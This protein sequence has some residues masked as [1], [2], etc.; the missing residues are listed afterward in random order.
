MKN[1]ILIVDDEKNIRTTL[2]Y[3]LSEEEYEIDTADDGEQAISILIG[4]EKRYDLVLLDIKMPYISGMDVLRRLRASK[5][6]TNIIMMTAYGTVKEA[7]EAMK[8]NVID[9]ISKPFSLE[10]I[11]KIIIAVLSREN[12]TENTLYT[13]EQYI[14]FAKL[15]ITNNNFIKAEEILKQAIGKNVISPESYNLLGIIAE[16][17][18]NFEIAQKYYRAA[19]A[20]DPSYKLALANLERITDV[21]CFNF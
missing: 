14:E 10:E 13:F 6:N 19:L 21:D 2:T 5:N 8:L 16:Y 4:E 17:N 3:F 1:K 11:K 15:N 12:L 9:F 20:F 7:V 18:G